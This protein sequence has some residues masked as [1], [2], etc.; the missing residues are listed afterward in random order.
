MRLEQSKA[1][2]K[3]PFKSIA[4]C[5][6]TLFSYAGA[7]QAD[8]CKYRVGYSE[9]AGAQE[10]QSTFGKALVAAGKQRGICVTVMDAALDVNKQLQAVN[11]FVAQKMDA[12]AIYPLSPDSL[13]PALTR[14]RDA[15]I[16]VIGLSATIADAQPTESILPYDALYDQNSGVQ[17]AHLL[18][19]YVKE[20]LAGKGSVIGVGIGIP[21]PGLKFMVDNYKKGVTTDSSIDWLATVDNPTD[22]LAGAQRVMNQALIRFQGTEIGA[23]MAYNTSSAVGAY[24]ALRASRRGNDVLVVGQNG[25]VLG[26]DALREGKLDAVVDLV[27]WR[28]G[29]M[30][31]DLVERVIEGKEHPTLTFGRVE[32]YTQEAL[33]N[34]LD[35]TTALAQISS[36]ELTCENGGCPSDAEAMKAY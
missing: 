5:L 8:D 25:D 3:Q 1:R 17:G 16:K 12:I 18:A 7:A 29:L 14:A 33:T 32:L 11:L 27:P 6:L 22:D 9:P 28:S 30:V 13:N 10:I 31:A 26:I 23:V 24:N 19:E 2:T 36:G 34:R 15:G 35:W 20:K 4:A 21:V